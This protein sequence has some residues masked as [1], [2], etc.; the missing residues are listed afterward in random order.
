MHTES[1]SRTLGEWLEGLG[2]VSIWQASKLVTSPS[3]DA[4]NTRT[5][6]LQLKDPVTKRVT[7][8]AADN[9]SKGKLFNETFFPP[10]NPDIPPIP[11]NFNYPEP[12]WAFT[13]ITNKQIH[14]IETLQSIQKWIS[15][16][17]DLHTR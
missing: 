1:K 4:G 15:S 9:D 17:L 6:T 5:P 8:E 7:R 2:Q 10:S 13:N 14:F 16:Q 11:Q 12:L 3:T